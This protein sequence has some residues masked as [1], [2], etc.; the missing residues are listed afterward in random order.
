MW[1]IDK[2]ITNL[3]VVQAHKG[4]SWDGKG[5]SLAWLLK[6]SETLPDGFK[7]VPAKSLMAATGPEGI[8]IGITPRVYDEAVKL[9]LIKT[10][11]ESAAPSSG[12]SSSNPAQPSVP[13]SE[14]LPPFDMEGLFDGPP[15]RKP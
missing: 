14:D 5:T 9:K 12:N 7:M 13:E 15:P 6:G 8:Y 3:V 10:S 4:D 1:Q 2:S 11:E